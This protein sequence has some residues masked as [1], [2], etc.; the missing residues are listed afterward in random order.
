M[1]WILKTTFVLLLLLTAQLSFASTWYV[2]PNTGEYGAEDGTSLATAF[3]GFADMAGSYASINAGDKV[4][5]SGDFTT[6]DAQSSPTY[7]HYFNDAG[8]AGLPITLDGDCDGDGVDASIDAGATIS[9]VMQIAD[10]NNLTIKNFELRNG[11]GRGLLLYNVATD[12][13]DRGSIIVDDVYIHD[14]VGD[15]VAIGVDSRGI[16]FTVKNSTFEDIGEDGIYH[17]GSNFITT[18][19]TLQRVSSDST[20]GDCIQLSGA[21]QNFI[22]SGNYCDHRN[23][24][25]KQCYIASV[26]TDAGY[27]VVDNNICLRPSGE[28]TSATYGTY[29]ETASGLSSITRNYYRGGRTAIQYLG[30]GTVD[31]RSNVSIVLDNDVTTAARCIS[32]GSSAGQTDIENNSCSGGYDGIVSD[33]A[34]VAI[35][36]NNAVANITN[37]CIDKKSTDLESYNGCYAYGGDL[38]SNDGTPTTA[39]LNTVTI[40]PGWVGGNSPTSL[41]GFRLYPGSPL[42]GAGIRTSSYTDYLGRYFEYKPSVGAFTYGSR[43]IASYMQY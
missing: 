8:S 24:A 30:A 7:L 3:D 17:K 28:G 41:S 34:S 29:V 5:Y 39:G 4:C 21:Y 43:D 40:S 35:I 32:L 19:N 36:R 9:R 6:S 27:G 1:K 16:G 14:I 20:L 2:Q 26:P 31:I 23:T 33:S 10:N 11:T 25:T 18:N 12:V 15:A 38:V 13:T 22:M 37:D 42:I